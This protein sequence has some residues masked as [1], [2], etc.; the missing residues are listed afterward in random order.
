LRNK[1]WHDV[2]FRTEF[3]VIALQ[4]VF[5]IVV[6]II[7]AVSFDY[8]Y[9]DILQT[10]L[11]G[12]AQNLRN[13][14]M[15]TGKQLF[16]SIQIV[17]GKNFLTFFS[18]ALAVTFIFS[19][20]I[21]RMTLSPARN[22]LQS[23]KR[24]VSDIA[25]ELRTPLAVIK[26]NM[27]VALLDEALVHDVKRIFK[28]SI[29]ELDRT[30]GIINNLL[31]FSNLVHPEQIQ[32]ARVDM[33]LVIDTA[34]K[35]LED[36]RKKKEIKITV[37]KIG[38]HTVWGNMIALEQIV[39][40][41]VKNA[42]NYTSAGGSVFVTV[43]PDYRGNIMVSVS[44]T[45]VGISQKDLIHIFEPFYRA[46]RSRNRATGSSGLGL[47]IVSELVKLHSGKI[48]V[49]SRLKQGTTV[50]VVLPYSKEEPVQLVE[51]KS[52]DNEVSVSYLKKNI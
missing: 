2:F 39:G 22:A 24:F 17:R 42:V 48:N 52:T 6:S 37:K 31:T 33:G 23:Q 11:D 49:R 41:I 29:E 10:L 27:E 13:G 51:T 9:K 4:I 46:E 1:Y 14:N 20:I 15:I 5:A 12:I 35:K 50:T 40:N 44:D 25:H 21:A 28:S 38:P 18:I 43:E 7:V 45:G 8:L 30:S 36:L 34:V 16:D 26:T 3:N 32:F 47:T 19:Y